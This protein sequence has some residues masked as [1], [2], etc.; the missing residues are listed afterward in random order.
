MS[1]NNERNPAIQAI[2]LGSQ[3]SGASAVVPG[4][5]FRKRSRIKNVYLVDQIGLNNTDYTTDYFTLTLQDNSATPVAYATVS[6]SGKV[7]AAVTQFPGV[8]DDGGGDA[9]DAPPGLDTD[10][11]TQPEVDV[12]A[13]T[14]LNVNVVGT[15]AS[16]HKVLTNAVL[17]I[18]SYPL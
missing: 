18:E 11:A 1:M 2:Y 15:A 8:L 4:L 17:L 9:F 5:Y 6:T 16:T 3:A 7:V 14:M 12:P 10:S 13:G